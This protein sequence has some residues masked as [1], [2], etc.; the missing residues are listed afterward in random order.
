[1]LLSACHLHYRYGAECNSKDSNCGN[2][3]D[4]VATTR[5]VV[6]T[7]LI[8]QHAMTNADTPTHL[9]AWQMKLQLP[10]LLAR[11][12]KPNADCLVRH[13]DAVP[14]NVALLHC[15]A[16]ACAVSQLSCVCVVTQVCQQKCQQESVPPQQ[17]QECQQ[18]SCS[19]PITCE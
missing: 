2:N 8:R 9:P 15:A 4:W 19:Q 18:K 3:H 17:V 6:L 13:C 5:Q 11:L 14:V 10:H 12:L 16:S 7:R 1:M